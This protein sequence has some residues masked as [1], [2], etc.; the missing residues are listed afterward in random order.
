MVRHKL[1]RYFV[2]AFLL[3]SAAWAQGPSTS[4][5]QSA[6]TTKNAIACADTSVSA[7]TITCTTAVG[8]TGYANDQAFDVRVAN[9]ATA[10]TTININGLGAKAVTY[11][12]TTVIIAGVLT[13]GG[14][15][16]MQYDGTRFVVQGVVTP[17]TAQL[18]AITVSLDG[19]GVAITTGDVGE[20]PTAAYACTIN[21]VDIS[22]DQSGSITIDVWKRAGAIPTSAQK[23]SASAP[24]T[25]S[26][27]QLSQNGSISGWTT[28][29]SV[30]DVFGFTVVTAATVQKVTGQIWCQ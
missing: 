6:N 19:G 2:V 16:R 11:N 18:H 13:A 26:S 7:N 27:A 20:F 5:V 21:R 3:H 30:G 15:Y 9:S 1:A 17:A 23:I 14:T 28:A 12:G 29:V 25:L 24:L 22:A 8:F 4:S 10:A